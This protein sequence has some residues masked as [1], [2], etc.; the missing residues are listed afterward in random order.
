M[1]Q[2]VAVVAMNIRSLPQRIWMS[3]ATLVAVGIVVAVLLAFLALSN[4]FE[5]T[6]NTSGSDKIAVM[7]RA[8]SQGEMSSV[9]L[10]DQLN[11]MELAPGI[12]RDANGPVVSA[13]L[14]VIVDGTKRSTNTPVNLPLRGLELSGVELRENFSIVE[15]RM[16]EPGRNELVVGEAVQT[17]FSG[18]E[19]NKK[20]RLGQSEWTVVGVF[21]AGGSVFGSELWGDLKTVQSQFNRGSSAQLL[22]AKLA[23]PGDVSEIQ[24]Y[25]E[26]EPQLN[27]DVKTEVAYYAEQ[28]KGI[29]NVIFYLGWPLAI[30]MALGALA[31]ALNTMYNSVAQRSMEIATLRAIGFS[32]VSAFIGTLVESLALAAI[33]GVLGSLAAYL[34]F[35]GLTTSTLS[36]NFTQVVFDFK[37]SADSFISGLKLALIVG[38]IGGFFPALRAARLPVVIAFKNAT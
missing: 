37:L 14:Y 20:V 4:G 1:A 19:L 13:E 34:F 38:F 32:G 36:G 17:E 9:L 11:I 8:G 2:I 7:L 33:G 24:A 3:I 29:T 26:N 21:S 6:L 35:D 5:K 28:S 22:R 23:T 10:R 31:G 15:G 16:F 12:S 27:L 25:I 18:F 30:A